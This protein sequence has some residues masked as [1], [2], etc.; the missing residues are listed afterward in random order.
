MLQQK[1]VYLTLFLVIIVLT[2]SGCS[3][4]EQNPDSPAGQNEISQGQAAAEAGSDVKSGKTVVYFFW[5]E[6]CPHCRKQKPWLEELEGKYPA[7]E[8]KMLE[9]YRD[10]DNAKFFQEMAQAYGVQARAVPATFIG[11]FEPVF[12]FSESMKPGIE[13]KI[14]ICL[15][16]GCINPNSKL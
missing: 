16:E 9:T 12:G 1:I 11:D 14:K 4:A 7:L 8:V 5:G 10:R 6:S 2:V 15:D 3:P 13:D